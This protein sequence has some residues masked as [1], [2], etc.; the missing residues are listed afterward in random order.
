MQD[1]EYLIS[2]LLVALELVTRIPGLLISG[3]PL[4]FKVVSFPEAF[5][6]SAS[7]WAA[8]G[9]SVNRLGVRPKNE[10]NTDVDADEKKEDYVA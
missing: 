1:I 9:S 4:E 7:V 2:N 10:R 5:F 6:R 8:D 3:V